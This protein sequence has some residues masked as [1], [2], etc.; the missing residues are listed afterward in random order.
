MGRCIQR[1]LLF[2]VQLL[3]LLLVLEQFWTRDEGF[4]RVERGVLSSWSY[5]E[6]SNWH[7]HKRA[8]LLRLAQFWT[9][10]EGFY[11]VERSLEFLRS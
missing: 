9:R 5:A 3:R 7:H 11:R 4:Y 10:D 1:F 2:F 8:S 6:S